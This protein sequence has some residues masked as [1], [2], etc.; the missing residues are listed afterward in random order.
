MILAAGLGTRLAPFTDHTPKPLFTINQRPV[1]DHTIARLIDAGCDLI[2]INTHHLH[3]L[4]ADH[5]CRTAYNIDVCI[6]HEPE[7]LGTGGAI[8]N[9]ANVW[10]SGPLMVVNGDIVCDIDL[11]RVMSFHQKNHCPVTM[12]MHDHPSF[13]IVSVDDD[14]TVV[15]FDRD[16][17]LLRPV[18]KLA[19]TGIHVLEPEVLTHLPPKGFA[20]I[21]DAYRRMLIDGRPIK[22]MVVRDHYWNDIG[23][24]QRY[25]SAAFDHMAPAAYEAAFGKKPGCPVDIRPLHGDGSDRQWFR[26]A[27]EQDRMILADHHIRNGPPPQEADA[28]V[29]IGRHLRRLGVPAP[30]IFLADTFSGLV[31]VED[32]GDQHLQAHVQNKSDAVR[33][34]FY[35]RIIDHWTTMAMEGKNGFNPAWT[36]QTPSYDRELILEKEARYFTEAFLQ[37]YLG[38]ETS[39]ED[40]ADEF[41]RLADGALV[42]AV[43]GFIHRDFQSRNIMINGDRIGFIDFQGGRLGPVQYDLAA[44]L[45]DPYTAL[46]NDLQEQLLGYAVAKLSQRYG[47]EAERFLKGYAFCAV[48]RNLQM[49]GAFAYLSQVKDKS[50]FKAYI[51]L[52]VQ[53]LR[54]NLNKIP[55]TALPRLKAVAEK[56]ALKRA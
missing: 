26:L 47:I 11:S 32:L 15:S 7:I 43:T 52:A 3:Q 5:V 44:L 46:S 39:F 38:W 22:A 56:L 33:S 45:I 50:D 54:K 28:Y 18:R 31:F 10:D 8:A 49:L 17:P 12:V 4:I 24:P 48:T 6:R 35:R 41:G 23:T 27:W 55:A 37:A 13:N 25:R 21:I 1:L 51:P 34:I 29:A 14:D 20:N 40:L 53:R 16:P 30:R 36:Y 19:F 9:I 2:I 42:Y